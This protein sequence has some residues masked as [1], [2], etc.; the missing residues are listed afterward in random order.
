MAKGGFAEENVTP[1][2]VDSMW[3]TTDDRIRKEQAKDSN[4]ITGETFLK[5]AR[6]IDQS[7]EE[8][9]MVSQTV[10]G[11]QKPFND[12]EMAI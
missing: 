10:S 5:D 11:L 12:D 2:V 3:D 9:N 8:M 7:I 6:Q 1:H 4:M